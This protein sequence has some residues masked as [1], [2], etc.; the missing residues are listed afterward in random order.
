MSKTWRGQESVIEIEDTNGN[1]VPVGI[2][3][4]P[5]VTA[6]EQDVQEL[7]GAGSTEF[8]DLQKTETSPTSSGTVSEF[9]I[10][11]WDDLV[12][13]D[14]T[15][16]KLDDSADVKQFDV[17]TIFEAADGST[18]EIILKDAYV[19]GGIELGGSRDDFIG[20]DLT[21]VGRTIEITN[22]DASV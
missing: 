1:Q 20:L 18:K 5:A 21:F 16:G 11:A 17:T 10:D 13:Y 15:A 6:P 7:R 12:D 3:D 2:L 22:T 4:D 8:Q 9:A 14:E 19:D